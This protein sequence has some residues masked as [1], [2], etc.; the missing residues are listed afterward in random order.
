MKKNQQN[1]FQVLLLI[2]PTCSFAADSG[3]SEDRIQI[4]LGVD[5]DGKMAPEAFV[6]FN[7]GNGWSSGI[8]LRSRQAD[9]HDSI[10]GFA[11]SRVGNSES[12]ER[13]R[14]NLFSYE[15]IAGKS[16]WQFGLDY[17]QVNQEKLQFG[18]F[19]MPNP[20]PDNPAVAGEYVAFDNLIDVKITKP[21]LFANYTMKTSTVNFRVG[22]SVSPVSS[23][24]VDQ[25]T[26]FVPIVSSTGS[27]SSDTSQDLAYNM[28]IQLEIKTESSINVGLSYYYELLPMN[29]GIAA[30]NATAD[31]FID[32]TVDVEQE[33][34]RVA[35]RAIFKK[36]M[37]GNLKPVIG[38]ITEDIDTKNFNTG[39]TAST[40]KS[41]ILFGLESQF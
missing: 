10:E 35:V 27:R 39:K 25:E 41:I 1:V 16:V 20:Y 13:I 5:E 23:L 36:P 38:Y 24:S 6:P 11:D 19:Q 17:E 12:E 21:N 14:L 40:S 2:L 34:S 37:A 30:L 29:Y 28:A 32:K 26:R 33:S 4:D 18:Y 31:G 3:W 15:K 22:L 7:W 8:G 9:S